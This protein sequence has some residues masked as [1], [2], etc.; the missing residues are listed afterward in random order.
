LRVRPELTR[1]KHLTG[2]FRLLAL[3]ANIILGYKDIPETN[4]FANYENSL[5]T[6]DKSFITLAQIETKSQKVL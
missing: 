3:L 5:I 6:D 1:G 4:T 2:T